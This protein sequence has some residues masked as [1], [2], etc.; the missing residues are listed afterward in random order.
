M[1]KG[2]EFGIKTWYANHILD[3]TITD[4]SELDMGMKRSYAQL[5]KAMDSGI[6]SWYKQSTDGVIFTAEKLLIS[7]ARKNK[8]PESD[9]GS[10]F[11]V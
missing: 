10:K 2:I 6:T 5:T 11:G 8:A 1:K 9:S 7:W 3:I 4:S